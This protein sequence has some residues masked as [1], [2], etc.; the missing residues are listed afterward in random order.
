MMKM[1]AADSQDNSLLLVKMIW[2]HR[3]QTTTSPT[4]T[5]S[6]GDTLIL[7]IPEGNRPLLVSSVENPSTLGEVA[8][9]KYSALTPSLPTAFSD[10]SS[11]SPLTQTGTEYAPRLPPPANLPDEDAAA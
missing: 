5:Y 1:L 7:F 9:A 6:P 8:C 3:E 10:D 4:A 2:V 11:R